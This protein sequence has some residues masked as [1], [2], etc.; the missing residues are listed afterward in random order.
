MVGGGCGWVGAGGAAGQAFWERRSRRAA[1][2]RGSM[3]RGLATAAIVAALSSWTLA[4]QP[5]RAAQRGQRRAS[6]S[7]SDTDDRDS[8]IHATPKKPTA[9]AAPTEPARRTEAAAGARVHTPRAAAWLGHAPTG[10]PAASPTSGTAGR[11]RAAGCDRGGRGGKVCGV[12]SV[13]VGVVWVG[14]S[15][16]LGTLTGVTRVGC[17]RRET[18]PGPQ[19]F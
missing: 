19:R 10:F 12:M 11:P 8:A 5:D 6:H 17:R 1:P 16:G 7:S 2:S 15:G 9:H 18:R 3:L 4:P 14:C 13:G